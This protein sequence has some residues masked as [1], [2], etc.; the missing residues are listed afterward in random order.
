VR[1]VSSFFLHLP[2]LDPL[3]GVV[4]VLRFGLARGAIPEGGCIIHHEQPA[5]NLISN[6]Q[7]QGQIS[8]GSCAEVSVSFTLIKQALDISFLPFARRVKD[9]EYASQVLFLFPNG[10]DSQLPDHERLSRDQRIR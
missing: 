3:C 9:V 4:Q 1:G 6:Y 8:I 7:Q 5:L 2:V 10:P